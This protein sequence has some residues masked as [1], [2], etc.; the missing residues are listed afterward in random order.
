MNQRST[1]QQQQ[2]RRFQHDY[3]VNHNTALSPLRPHAANENNNEPR[4]HH[5]CDPDENDKFWHGATVLEKALVVC[6]CKKDAMSHDN[7]EDMN[8]MTHYLSQKIPT[9]ATIPD[10]FA[11]IRATMDRRLQELSQ[12]EAAIVSP[13]TSLSVPPNGSDTQWR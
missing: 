10:P 2:H 1:V 3:L 4:D 5:H 8:S 13:T 6:C 12:Y 11:S 7:D 9:L